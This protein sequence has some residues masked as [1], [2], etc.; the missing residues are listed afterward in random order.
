MEASTASMGAQARSGTG[1]YPPHSISLIKGER[2]KPT[3][4]SLGPYED[5]TIPEN[6]RRAH[7]L[8][9]LN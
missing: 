1:V 8:P 9:I 6:V 2:R 4:P 3:V 7:R 5:Q